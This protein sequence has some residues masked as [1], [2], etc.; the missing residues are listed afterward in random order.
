[1]QAVSL[2]QVLALICAFSVSSALHAQS[3]EEL[4]KCSAISEGIQRLVCF[5]ALA[6]SL[7]VNAPTVENKPG[8]GK[9]QISV[10]QSPIDDSRNVYLSL[11]ANEAITGKYGRNP[12]P[13]IHFRC[14][15]K[16]TEGYINF[17]VYLGTESTRITTRVDKD[18]AQTN[19]WGISTDR[20]AAFVPQAIPFL[21]TLMNKET[22][23]VQVTPYG[24][25]TVITTF[26]IRGL[27]ESATPLTEA[28]NRK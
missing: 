24:E 7:G 12:T 3:K 26:D 6:H 19:W 16:K 21:K 11:S 14:K 4:A 28:C 10:E 2:C 27:A 9:W 13:T 22:L 5:D 17:D 8:K 20:Q 18:K 15:E 25:N 1:M 23:L